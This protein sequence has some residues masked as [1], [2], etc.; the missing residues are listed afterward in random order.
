MHTYLSLQ[1]DGTRSRGNLRNGGRVLVRQVSAQDIWIGYTWD[2]AC[3][4]T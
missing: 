2:P 4:N 3:E 1:A